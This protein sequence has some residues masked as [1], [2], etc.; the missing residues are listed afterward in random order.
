MLT[1]AKKIAGDN[2]TSVLGRVPVR[3]VS[4]VMKGIRIQA[5]FSKR[6][7]DRY[8]G[9]LNYQFD[10]A[11]L[12][13]LM[14]LQEQEQMYAQKKKTYHLTWNLISYL[15]EAGNGKEMSASRKEVEQEVRR[16][17]KSMEQEPGR[18]YERLREYFHVYQTGQNPNREQLWQSAESRRFVENQEQKE[19]EARKAGSAPLSMSASFFQNMDH[20]FRGNRLPDYREI[21]HKANQSGLEKYYLSIYMQAFAKEPD[22]VKR[23]QMVGDILRDFQ[24]S[25]VLEYLETEGNAKAGLFMK[26]V[27]RL[28]GEHEEYK[29]RTQTEDTGKDDGRPSLEITQVSEFAGEIVPEL[30]NELSA[31]FNVFTRSTE[32]REKIEK[33]LGQEI[34]KQTENKLRESAWKQL[35]E[36]AKELPGQ[37]PRVQ[38]ALLSVLREQFMQRE[39]LSGEK[40]EFH[41]K[42]GN[43][44]DPFYEGIQLILKEAAGQNREGWNRETQEPERFEAPSEE[45]KKN[46][47][48]IEQILEETVKKQEEEE[49]FLEEHVTKELDKKSVEDQEEWKKESGRRSEEASGKESE[50]GSEEAPWKE[51]GRGSEEASGKESGREPGEGLEQR[52]IAR[53]QE[54]IGER[55]DRK[56]EENRIYQERF[57]RKEISQTEQGAF[58][59]EPL[60]YFPAEPVGNVVWEKTEQLLRKTMESEEFSTLWRN[61]EEHREEI[62]QTLFHEQILET[63]RGGK[64]S[65]ILENK[66]LP[67]EGK[68]TET[69]E[70]KTEETGRTEPID[71]DAFLLKEEDQQMV[72]RYRK[73]SA[74]VQEILGHA[75]EI[76]KNTLVER[77]EEFKENFYQQIEELVY[78]EEPEEETEEELFSRKELRMLL[79]E[80]KRQEEQREDSFHQ[81]LREQGRRLSE[82]Y[83]GSMPGITLEENRNPGQWK[84][85]P[86]SGP[87]QEN[88][89]E[90]ELAVQKTVKQEVVSFL[91]NKLELYAYTQLARAFEQEPQPYLSAEL[92]RQIE[93]AGNGLDFLRDGIKTS[94]GQGVRAGGETESSGKMTWSGKKEEKKTGYQDSSLL[95]A[96]GAEDIPE[97][98]GNAFLKFLQRESAEP[99]LKTVSLPERKLLYLSLAHGAD[100]LIVREQVRE[101]PE[102]WKEILQFKEQL[103]KDGDYSRMIQGDF[104]FLKQNKRKEELAQAYQALSDEGRS[105]LEAGAREE[106]LLL[107]KTVTGKEEPVQAVQSPVFYGTPQSGQMPDSRELWESMG[108]MR[109][110]LLQKEDTAALENSEGYHSAESELASYFSKTELILL[111]R[112]GTKEKDAA[113]KKISF[114]EGE[115]GG[116]QENK[117]Y[118]EKYFQNTPQ[119]ST[120]IYPERNLLSGQNLLGKAEPAGYLQ[121]ERNPLPWE[122]P[123]ARNPV[124]NYE[125]RLLFLNEPLRR[126]ILQTMRQVSLREKGKGERFQGEMY[127][128]LLMQ[129]GRGESHPMENLPANEADFLQRRGNYDRIRQI[130][131]EQELQKQVVLEERIQMIFREQQKDTAAKMKP[132]E[133]ESK[134]FQETIQRVQELD[135]SL[136]EYRGLLGEKEE[137]ME[138][139][140]RRLSEQEKNLKKLQGK[141]EEQEL[142]LESEAPMEEWMDKLKKELI[143]EQMR[144]GR[145]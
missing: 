72:E 21:F 4:P 99:L 53:I 129:E 114:R 88:Q 63:S 58:W 144:N 32:I 34:Q 65:N 54:K 113:G 112:P 24:P 78:R 47:E 75:D 39:E 110:E 79:E 59:Q 111:L 104:R 124:L 40:R 90:G 123:E 122:N 2:K 37:D 81:M 132:S 66:E 105:L 117:G 46:W 84:K 62:L 97:S 74:S 136:L 69:E 57:S 41:E 60:K 30:F 130:K 33:L 127:S 16:Q 93:K 85:E 82:R 107:S 135:M 5:D 70:T 28:N 76:S 125:G 26:A 36:R 118:T 8:S 142:Y 44:G 49:K 133:E 109:K 31:D 17:L 56:L 115:G 91:Q 108:R 83:A 138:E 121:P 116:F 141:K 98:G 145:L 18:E 131:K 23:E 29:A 38:E 52:W 102:L 10:P 13:L 73:V 67:E 61:L 12:V 45:Y 20:L 89:P 48:K 100:G 35:E 94:V 55:I 143:L 134:E 42:P 95:Q 3:S 96:G 103:V 106:L 15:I 43:M 119:N 14:Q 68:K 9:T 1:S 19:E 25:M 120:G 137:Q 22:E 6:I 77:V 87:G 128:H 64:R 92:L 139:L 140:S 7:I 126:Q 11:A 101:Q 86:D 27:K 51:S 80:H 71:L 50:R